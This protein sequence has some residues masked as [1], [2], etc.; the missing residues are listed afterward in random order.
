MKTEKEIIQ[1]APNW[2][3]EVISLDDLD[4]AMRMVQDEIGVEMG[5]VCGVYWSGHQDA[6]K[7]KYLRRYH[8]RKYIALELNYKN[9]EL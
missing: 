4:E 8:V 5:D 9:I 6:W 1:S 3:A 7:K 2:M